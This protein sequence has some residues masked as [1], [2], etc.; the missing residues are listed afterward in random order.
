MKPTSNKDAQAALQFLI[1]YGW[2]FIVVLAVIAGLI[3][4]NPIGESQQGSDG[5]YVSNNT[6]IRLEHNETTNTLS[7]RTTLQKPTPCGNLTSDASIMPRNDVMNE[8]LLGVMVEYEEAN[9]TCAQVVTPTNITGT[10]QAE[11]R[12]GLAV[13]STVDGFR[14][15]EYNRTQ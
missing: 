14:Q 10:L 9:G 3:A 12:P 6:D 11:E 8:S 13:V 7:Y 2:I 15:L 4:L 1:T 5:F